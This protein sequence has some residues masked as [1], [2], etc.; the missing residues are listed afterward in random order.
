[1]FFRLHRDLRGRG[2][3][4]TGEFDFAPHQCDEAAGIWDEIAMTEGGLDLI[5]VN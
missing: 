5:S 2:K 3:S 4:F 1:L